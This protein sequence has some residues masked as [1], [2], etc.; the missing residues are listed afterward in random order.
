MGK[1]YFSWE[2]SSRMTKLTSH[3]EHC[4]RPS[5]LNPGISGF[6]FILIRFPTPPVILA[7]NSR[8]WE[9]ALPHCPS[10]LSERIS[11]V[12]F[13]NLGKKTKRTRLYASSLLRVAPEV[14]GGPFAPYH[15]PKQGTAGF[16]LMLESSLLSDAN[17]RRRLYQQIKDAQLYIISTELTGFCLHLQIKQGQGSDTN[18]GT[19]SFILVLSRSPACF[20]PMSAITLLNNIPAWLRKPLLTRQFWRSHSLLG[21]KSLATNCMDANHAVPSSLWGK[22][23][24]VAHFL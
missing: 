2:R 11:H 14:G 19:S 23:Q 13:V 15:L 5:P 1:N 20:L 12:V 10:E 24:Y 18:T 21:K 6:F 16:A 4:S 8:I 9:Y 7:S 3:S 17:W 22:E